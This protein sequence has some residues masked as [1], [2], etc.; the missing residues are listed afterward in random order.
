MDK[1]IY[2]YVIDKET[3]LPIL[4]HCMYNFMGCSHM[5]FGPRSLYSITYKS[6]QIGFS[7]YQRKYNHGYLAYLS[8]TC[9]QDSISIS[10]NYK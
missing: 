6:G 2:F 10:L 4:E 8:A 1:L 7:I 5:M 9:Y 3:F